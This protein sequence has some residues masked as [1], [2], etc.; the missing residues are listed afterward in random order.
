ML[1]RDAHSQHMLA[2][3]APPAAQRVPHLPLPPPPPRF[4]RRDVRATACAHESRL[5]NPAMHGILQPLATS[6]GEGTR[7]QLT[8]AVAHLGQPD[9]Y[10]PCATEPPRATCAVSDTVVA[11]LLSR[12]T[13]RDGPSPPQHAIATLHSEPPL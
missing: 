7:A 13:D 2:P 5:D 1:H 11:P 3:L 8:H 4:D 10:S 12:R 9:P 6:M